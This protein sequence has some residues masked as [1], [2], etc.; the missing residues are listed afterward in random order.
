[1]SVQIKKK[2][3][4]SLAFWPRN[5]WPH[6]FYDRAIWNLF[7]ELSPRSRFLQESSSCQWWE[8]SPVVTP[9]R[10]PRKRNKNIPLN[11]LKQINQLNQLLNQYED[12]CHWMMM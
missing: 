2:Y 4:N 9:R 7:T 6:I 3:I 5:M 8:T 12:H 10:L 1:M 11:Q